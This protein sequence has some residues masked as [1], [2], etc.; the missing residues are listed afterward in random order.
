MYTGQARYHIASP[1]LH[2]SVNTLSNLQKKKKKEV[3]QI[4]Y[5]NIAV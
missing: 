2:D 4:M 5:N 1:S 3:E